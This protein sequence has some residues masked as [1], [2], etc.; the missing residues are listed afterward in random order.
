M[1]A[2]IFEGLYFNG[3]RNEIWK[4]YLLASK[5]NMIF[6]DLR[7]WNYTSC[8]FSK[9]SNKIETDEKAVIYKTS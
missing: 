1:H 2:S 5:E 4:I 3:L 6:K 7:F 8:Y 9:D